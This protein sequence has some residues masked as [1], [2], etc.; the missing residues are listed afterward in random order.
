MAKFS[1]RG[2]VAPEGRGILQNSDGGTA[3]ISANPASNRH[4]HSI[5][6]TLEEN[7]RPQISRPAGNTVAKWL[8]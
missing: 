7:A 8:R 6:G 4:Y 3:R 1:L 5:N 2:G